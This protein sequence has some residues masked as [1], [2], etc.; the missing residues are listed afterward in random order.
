MFRQAIAGIK[1]RFAHN[2]VSDFLKYILT[3]NSGKREKVLWRHVSCNALTSSVA[4]TYYQHP[5]NT[6]ES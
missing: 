2:D 5:E 4:F 6:D 3:K 1:T